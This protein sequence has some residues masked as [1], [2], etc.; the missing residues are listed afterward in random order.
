MANNPEQ[1]LAAETS[2]KHPGGRPSTYDPAYCD[3]VIEW[4]KAGKS[5]AWMAAELD[6]VPNTL[7]N[8]TK[9]HPEFLSA[10]TR[11]ITKSQQWWEDVG[12]S[13]LG[14][15]KFQGNVWSRSMAARFPNDW[16]E[17]TETKSELSG[18]DGKPIE[19]V[20]RLECVIVDPAD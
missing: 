18:P 14:A 19:T 17:K 7:D 1:E 9:E 11:A 6:V 15:D 10:L 8:W 4:G 16:R 13:A 2:T 12:Q 3:A 20:N 5:K